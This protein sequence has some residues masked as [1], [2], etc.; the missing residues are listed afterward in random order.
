MKTTWEKY[1]LVFKPFLRTKHVTQIWKSA[2]NFNSEVVTTG[3]SSAS[4]ALWEVNL[5]I[6]QLEAAPTEGVVTFAFCLKTEENH[7]KSQSVTANCVSLESSQLAY[8][9]VVTSDIPRAAQEPAVL[10][11]QAPLPAVNQ[12]SVS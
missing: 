9:P 2:S 7:G 1:T 4:L 10:P 8:S 11:T 12:E 5:L 3:L 6:Q